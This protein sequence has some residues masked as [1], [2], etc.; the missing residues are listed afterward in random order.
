MLRM[1][2]GNAG[3]AERTGI[4]GHLQS[5]FGEERTAFLTAHLALAKGIRRAHDKID[6]L[7]LRVDSDRMTPHHAR[8]LELEREMADAVKHRLPFR[9]PRKSD[10]GAG[11]ACYRRTSVTLQSGSNAFTAR[12]HNVS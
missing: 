4:Y 5:V 1:P 3:R 8:R 2:L 10:K 11:S 12:V 6:S 9:L 7:R